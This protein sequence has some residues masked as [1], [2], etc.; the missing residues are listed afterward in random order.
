[1]AT[2]SS[3]QEKKQDSVDPILALVSIALIVFLAAFAPLNGRM[4]G[5]DH[6]TPLTQV[7]PTGDVSVNVGS[8]F[9]ADLKYWNANCSHRWNSDSTCE[10]LVSAAQ[11]CGVDINTRSVYCA[12]YDAYL[13]QLQGE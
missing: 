10:A 6:K 3:K 2:F 7:G 11:S 5:S 9:A 13:Q 1:M 8:S 4:Y 12:K